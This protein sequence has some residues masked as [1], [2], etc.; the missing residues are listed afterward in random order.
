M[1]PHTA[2]LQHESENFETNFSRNKVT[3]YTQ[4]CRYWCRQYLFGQDDRAPLEHD[5][6]VLP[7]TPQTT[8]EVQPSSSPT[9]THPWQLGAPKYPPDPHL[10]PYHSTT[11]APSN[12]KG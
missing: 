9:T 11:H 6:W 2:L 3:I 1:N 7:Q 12:L 8:K 10:G 5:P 4:Y